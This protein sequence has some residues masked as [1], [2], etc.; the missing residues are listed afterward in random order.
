MEI[1]KNILSLIVLVSVAGIWYF[2]KKRPNPKYRNISALVALVAFIIFGVLFREEESKQVTTTSVASS[3]ALSSSSSSIEQSSSLEPDETSSSATSSSSKHFKDEDVQNYAMQLQ[4]KLNELVQDTGQV[5]TV[6]GRGHIIY[7]TVPQNFKYNSK[8]SLQEFAD[9]ALEIKNET[10]P[11]WLVENG[12]APQ[13]TSIHLHIKAED[14][15]TLAKEN[16]SGFMKIT[17]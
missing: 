13:E 16:F 14:G 12:Y 3:S 17:K 6:T 9:K 10:F 4:K 15:T 5:Y 1:L 11:M 2:I 7:L 8:D